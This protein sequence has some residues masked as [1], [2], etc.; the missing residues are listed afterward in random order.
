VQAVVGAFV[1]G[2]KWMSS[3]SAEDIARAMPEE[4]ALGD[5][6][7]YV[8]ALAASKPMYSPD[9][10]FVPGA[11]DTAYQVLK[12]FDSSVAGASVDLA[13]TYTSAF[14]EKALANN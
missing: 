7:I 3:H 14:V 5:R 10:R 12:V 8:K 13:K 11:V 9:G 6:A 2:L 1:R 4:Y